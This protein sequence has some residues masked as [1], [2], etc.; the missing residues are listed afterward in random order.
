MLKKRIKKWD[1]DRKH[2]YPD[3]LYAAKVALDRKAQGKRTTFVIRSRIVTFEEVQHYFRR[4]GVRDLTSLLKDATAEELTTRIECHTPEPE[5]VSALRV[6]ATSSKSN[7]LHFG[8][9][10]IAIPDLSQVDRVIQQ[11]HELNQLDKLL[12][13]GC[14][15]YN[16]LFEE[17]DWERYGERFLD[18]SSLESFYHNLFDGL[19]LLNSDRV[20][21]AFW[22]LHRAFNLIRDLLGKETLLFLPYLY[23]ILLSGRSGRKQDVLVKLLNFIA[24]MIET[25]SPHMHPV[26]NSVLL[27][28]R[29]GPENRGHFC[30]RAFRSVLDHLKLVFHDCEPD[31]LQFHQTPHLLCHWETS[32]VRY[33]ARSPAERW[34]PPRL[35]GYELTSLAIWNL[36]RDAELLDA[37]IPAAN[38]PYHYGGDIIG[39]ERRHWRITWEFTTAGAF[40]LTWSF[41]S[42]TI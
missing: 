42:S 29:M 8:F 16:S 27:L 4:K 32:Q 9:N 14:D 17:R 36:A 3:M 2:K 13:Y 6:A 1:L 23:H 7:V 30:S 38:M 34:N 28:H 5:Q 33:L 39:L 26:R 40:S 18:L 31:K 15:Y 20:E 25:T 41:L 24:Q 22:H 35:G 12:H 10:I 21:I 11:P 37:S 19:E